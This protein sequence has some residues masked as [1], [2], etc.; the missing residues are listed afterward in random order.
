MKKQ[1]AE[2]ATKL[3]RLKRSVILT[4]VLSLIVVLLVPSYADLGMLHAADTG[5]LP[6]FVT[7]FSAVPPPVVEDATSLAKE[8]FGDSRRAY[9]DFVNQL[10]ATYMEAKDKDFIV[11][12]NSGGWGWSLL[13]RS[14]GWS[15]ILT[16]IKSELDS[17]GYKLLFLDYQRTKRTL[18]GYL[19]ELV[20]MITH[21]P[22]KTKELASR[23]T[24]LTRHIPNLKVILAGESNGTVIVDSTMDILRDNPQVY[25]I[26]TGPPFWYQNTGRERA[27]VL[28]SNGMVPDSF[29][30]GDIF[31][32]GATT[33]EDLLGFPR[34]EGNSGNIMFYLGAPGHDYQWHYPGVYSQIADFIHEKLGI[35]W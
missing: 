13:D 35:K 12:F 19:E 20:D 26:Q 22:S 2:I 25:S 14:P 3:R 17:S 24:F 4:V 29:T 1:D 34:S 16:G 21:Y 27:L 6:L 15:S 28:T 5:G 11:V 31:A 8:L 9:E 10:L 32:M 7:N 23:V 18:R 30:Q 33:L